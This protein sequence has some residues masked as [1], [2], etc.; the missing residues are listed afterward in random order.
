[1]ASVSIIS[2]DYY[3]ERFHEIAFSSTGVDCIVQ[4]FKKLGKRLKYSIAREWKI[5]E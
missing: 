5:L 1:M 2:F 4:R 3:L